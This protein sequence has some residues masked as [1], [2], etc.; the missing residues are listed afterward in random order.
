[1]THVILHIGPHKTG[2]TYLQDVLAALRDRLAERGICF[3]AIWSEATG[4]TSHRDL[5]WA[6]RSGDLGRIPEQIQEILASGYRTVVVSSEDLSSM[7]LHQIVQLRTFFGPARIVYYVRRWPERLPSTWQEIVKHGYA[8]SL[9]EFFSAQVSHYHGFLMRDLVILDRYAAVFG[10]ENIRVVSYSYLVDNNIDIARHFLESLLDVTDVE[11]P[12][13]GRPNA[14][15]PM[16]DIEVIRALNAIHLRGGGKGSAAIRNWYLD[17]KDGLELTPVLDAM[18]ESVGTL[19][20]IEAAP[21]LVPASREI[22][23]RYTTSMVPPW[24]PKTLHELREVDVPFVRQ[25][26]LLRPGVSDMLR[27]ICG[28]YRGTTA[29]RV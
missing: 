12:D 19:R 8:E 9:P 15:L 26:Y 20:M 16:N 14:S 13:V 27:E 28:L 23:T 24:H 5:A 3:P 10:A 1:V 18:R 7:A 4:G 17:Q 22:L 2:T 21:L 25:D 11:P 29:E 6:I